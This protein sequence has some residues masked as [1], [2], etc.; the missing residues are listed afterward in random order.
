MRQ[1]ES[2]NDDEV[3]HELDQLFGPLD[4]EEEEKEEDK[5]N[6]SRILVNFWLLFCATFLVGVFCVFISL[7]MDFFDVI[8]PEKTIPLYHLLYKHNIVNKYE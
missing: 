8:L 1:N 5:N 6:D 2:L 3:K 7:N 4:D